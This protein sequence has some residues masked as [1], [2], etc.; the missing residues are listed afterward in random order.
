MI[1]KRKKN[2]TNNNVFFVEQTDQ[3]SDNDIDSRL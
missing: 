1:L 2:G 3:T